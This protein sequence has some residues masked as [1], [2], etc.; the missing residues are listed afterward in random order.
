MKVEKILIL[1]LLSIIYFLNSGCDRA[2]K[3]FDKSAETDVSEEFDRIWDFFNNENLT[4]SSKFNQYLAFHADDYIVLGENG[5]LPSNGEQQ[6]TWLYGFLKN[7]KPRFDITIDRVEVSG[8]LAY[9]LFHFHEEFTQIDTEEKIV[10]AM[11]SAI[12]IMRKDSFGN[13]RCVLFKSF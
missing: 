10:D 12:Y 2:D 3:I 6:F 5:N 7:H 11:R 4:D 9:I 1:I 13:W 8:D